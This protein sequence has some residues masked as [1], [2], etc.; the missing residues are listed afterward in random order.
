MLKKR[1]HKISGSSS[2]SGITVQHCW[3]RFC[4]KAIAIKMNHIPSAL[5]IKL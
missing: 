1:H 2:S 3:M 5:A 4:G